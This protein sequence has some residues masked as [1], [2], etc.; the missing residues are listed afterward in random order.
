MF[1]IKLGTVSPTGATLILVVMGGGGGGGRLSVQAVEFSQVLASFINISSLK[2]RHRSQDT[3]LI[4]NLYQD[5][6]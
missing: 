2:P 6:S 3:S 1:L 4:I 5:R